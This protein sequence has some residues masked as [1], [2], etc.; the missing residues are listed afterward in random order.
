MSNYAIDLR[1]ESAENVNKIS[2]IFRNAL[3]SLKNL[4]DL[5]QDLIN[6]FWYNATQLN[7]NRQLQ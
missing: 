1:W 5:N 6:N 2:E 4:D 7:F 3:E